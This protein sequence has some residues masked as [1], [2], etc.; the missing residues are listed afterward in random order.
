MKFIIVEVHEVMNESKLQYNSKIQV[1]CHSI[2]SLTIIFIQ[3]KNAILI[4]I[5]ETN[6]LIK[7]MIN[8][9]YHYN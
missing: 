8:T 5:K 6:K 7:C 4:Q 1:W 9:T 2:F 3:H